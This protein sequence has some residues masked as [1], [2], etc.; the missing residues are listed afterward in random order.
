M[1]L[2]IEEIE[3]NHGL[4]RARQERWSITWS[5]GHAAMDE[6]MYAEGLAIKE[7]RRR[8]PHLFVPNWKFATRPCML[9]HWVEDG[10]GPTTATDWSG[11]EATE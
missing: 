4:E 9:M 5:I 11:L 1:G 3:R 2:K 10:D 6:S 7:G 8:T